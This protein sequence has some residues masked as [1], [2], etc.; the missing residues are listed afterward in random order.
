MYLTNG[1][2]WHRGANQEVV[3]F[4]L[5]QNGRDT[6]IQEHKM[7]TKTLDS[8]ITKNQINYYEIANLFSHALDLLYVCFVWR[9]HRLKHKWTHMLHFVLWV[10][11]FVSFM[12]IFVLPDLHDSRCFAMLDPHNLCC[13]LFCYIHMLCCIM[14]HRIAMFYFTF[15]FLLL[16]KAIMNHYCNRNPCAHVT[17]CHTHQ[18]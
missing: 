11:A 13:G 12:L 3:Y 14:W 6:W 8:T 9:L 15:S 10:S 16:L 4:G 17:L 1:S 2:H 7:Q 18:S 5:P